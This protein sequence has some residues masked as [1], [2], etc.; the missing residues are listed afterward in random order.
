MIPYIDTVT[1]DEIIANSFKDYHVKGF[2]YI[3]LRRSPVET[4]KLYF[5]DGDVSKLP[6]V[7]NPHDHRYD[8]RTMV[9][10]GSSQNMWF[11]EHQRGRLY[12]KFLYKTPLLGGDGFTYDGEISLLEYRRETFGKDDRY[13]M[14]HD[15]I[16][17][18][19]M[20]E[21]ETVLCLVQYEDK[22]EDDKPTLTFIQ[23]K[24]PS[25]SSLYNKFTPDQVLSRLKR[26]RERVPS[27]NL[28]R[29]I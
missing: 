29:I 14:R 9:V 2:D 16:H 13:F 11:E 18:I 26:L 22:V 5:F 19:R 24:A 20:L 3:C 28:P 23:D 1:V 10:A 8:F 21:S 25:L 7:V 27:I 17:T 6:E 12:N 15:M 4:V